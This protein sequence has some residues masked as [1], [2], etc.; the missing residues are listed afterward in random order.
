MQFVTV[1]DLRSRSAQVWRRLS[2]ERDLVVTSRGKPIALLTSVAD[3][4]LEES[5]NAIRADRAMAAVEA[6][7]R[8]S[9]KMGGDRMTL[10]EIN[11][12][13]DDVR[14]RRAE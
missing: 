13:I 4:D 3:D 10:K 14:R 8:R 2:A 5:L 6:M 9:E 12:I 1:R 7:Q 11:A